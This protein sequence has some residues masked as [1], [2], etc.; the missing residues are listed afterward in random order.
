[1]HRIIHTGVLLVLIAIRVLNAAAAD[2]PM[3][4][5]FAK[6]DITP[7]KPMRLSGYGNRAKPYEGIDEALFVRVV[8]FRQGGGPIHVLASVDNLGFTGVYTKKIHQ[9]IEQQRPVD[10][11]QIALC[12]TH[13]HT[14]PYLVGC[15]SNLFATPLTEAEHAA[16]TQ[17]A[18]K[19]ADAIVAAVDTAIDDLKPGRMFLA[20]GKATFARNRR[21]LKDGKWTGFG[22]NPDGPV[23]HALPAI[24]I[25]DV[26]GRNVRGLIFNYACHCTTFGGEYNRVNGDWAGYA[27]KYLEAS[28]PNAVAL[29]TVGCGAD[30]NP[31]RNSAR[32]FE[33]AQSQGR[34]IAREVDRITQ[35][36]MSEVTA[37]VRSTFGY[38]GL[39]IDRP[40][41]DELRQRASDRS[42]QVRRH[43]QNMLATHQRMGELP[44][45]YPM[46]IQVWRFG[47]QF[48]MV[49]LG[50]EVCADYA[51]RTKR[52]FTDGPMW[53]T[54]YANDVFGYVSPEKMRDEG[55]YEVDGSMIYFN[56]PG[57]WSTGTEEIIFRRLRE[58]YD[59]RLRAGLS[60]RPP[61]SL[62]RLR[63]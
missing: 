26:N 59:D 50:G 41:L 37:A 58:L 57:R 54:A 15:A 40:S 3:Q 12:A 17:Y 27:A 5:G 19:L 11:S 32:A 46:P 49:F 21:I 62:S 7:A 22:V 60:S 48:T 61:Y 2:E 30:S 47:D 4:F 29:C 56:Q 55:G 24:K 36:E 52:D 13:T 14:A 53:V 51:L 6:V 43:A 38:A 33:L 25:T 9:R 45:T 1:M 10:R 16:A 63:Y 23:D 39:P 18:V 35:R 42:P 44:A 31:D 34:Q 20:E 28:H 8:V